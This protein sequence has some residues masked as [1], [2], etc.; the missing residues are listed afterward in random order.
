[1]RI[2][3]KY[4]LLALKEQLPLKRFF[5]NFFITGNARGIFSKYSHIRKNGQ[6]K[7]GYSTKEKAVK[8]AE[9]MSKKYE[10]IF[11]TYL[12]VFCGKYHVGKNLK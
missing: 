2:K 12:C 8:A 3:F 11:K 6:E 4:L 5:R 10:G 7:V 1:M 9:S